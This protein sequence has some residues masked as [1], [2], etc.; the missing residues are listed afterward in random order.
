MKEKIGEDVYLKDGGRVPLSRA[1]RANG[2]LF[3]SG[4]L[5]LDRS[6]AIVSG[7]IEAQT[8]QA[9]DNIKSVLGEAG[10]TIDDVVKVTVWLTD[11]DHF[12]EFNKTYATYFDDSPP[13][14]STVVS[15][16]LLPGAVVEIEA[17]AA[18]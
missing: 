14:R 8:R 3:L 10:L 5:G 11:K 2:F 12:Q 9:M 15:E 4:Q 1:I 18:Y 13:A 16:L 17:V 6:G 7:G